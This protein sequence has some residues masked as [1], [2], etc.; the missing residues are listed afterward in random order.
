MTRARSG[1]ELAEAIEHAV[2][3]SVVER[4]PGAVVVDAARLLAVC[5][6]LRDD[7]GHGFDYLASLTA[8][9][10]LDFF[11]V[12]Y[13]LY[14]LRNNTGAVLKVRAEGRGDP[15]V[16]SVSGIWLGA[17]LQER[18]TWDLMG[19]RFNGHP[20]LRRVLLWEG[21]P[22]HPLRKDFLEFDHR[23]IAMSAVQA[24]EDH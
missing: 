18:E 20:D 17:V 9:D 15:A 14:S 4:Q 21:F 2:P 24:A 3:G 16:P 8:V 5:R 6:H 11:E 1:G 19:V 7:P 13:H 23:T 10:Y 12:V 22:G